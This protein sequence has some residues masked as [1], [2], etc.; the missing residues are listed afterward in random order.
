LGLIL[1]AE[2]N[3]EQVELLQLDRPGIKVSEYL[4]QLPSKKLLKE[5]LHQAIEVS[6]STSRITLSKEINRNCQQCPKSKHNGDTHADIKITRLYELAEI[7]DCTPE[8]ILSYQQKST[9]T[10]NFNNYEGNKGVNI[11]VPRLFRRPNQKL[12]RP[13][14]QK[15]VNVDHIMGSR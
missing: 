1:C 12:G 5:K 10:N 15:Q 3:H 9:F 14:R 6:K 4:T 2:G 13:V 11:N 7:F 8:F